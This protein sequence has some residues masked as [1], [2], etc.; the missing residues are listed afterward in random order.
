MAETTDAIVV[1]AGVLGCAVTLGLSRR[2]L[3][4]ICVDMAPGAGMGSTSYSSALVRFHYSTLVGTAMAWEAKHR[5]ESWA[6]YLQAPSDS[7]LATYRRT[8]MLVLD[9][10]DL[11]SRRALPHFEVIGIPY[12]DIDAAEIRERFPPVDP[13]RY[14]PP[15]RVEDPGFW[16][17]A[18]GELGAFYSPE[19]G[20]VDDPVLATANL[21]ASAEAVDA[22]FW[23]GFSS[24]ES[25]EVRWKGEGG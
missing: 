21:K 7:P 23:F 11:G 3:R 4:V 19:G 12:D 9:T 17:P 15:R 22:R 6:E 20:F 2:G 18:S 25:G 14:W 8:G 1:G 16:A 13:S 24:R 5:W 10:P